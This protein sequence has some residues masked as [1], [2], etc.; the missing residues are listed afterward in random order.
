MAIAT[1]SIDIV[2]KLASLQEGLDRAGRLNEKAA[3]QIEQRWAALESGA[4]R[5]GAAIG[6]AFA[7]QEFAR[8]ALATVSAIDALNDAKDATGSTIERL[9]ALDEIA[10]KNGATMDTVTGALVKF[11]SV[12]KAADGKNGVSQALQAIGVDAAQLRQQDPADALR[13]VAVALT[14]FADNGEKARI[15]QEL[16]GKSIREVAPFLND[17]AAA[18]ELNGKVTQQQADEAE[19]FNKNLAALQATAGGFAR[20]LASEVVPYL[21]KSINL[22]KELSSGPGFFTATA[23]VFKGN[24]FTDN[25]QAYQF[26]ASKLGAIDEKLLQTQT[27]LQT[28]GEKQGSQYLQKKIERL[29]TERQELEKFTNAY[30][31]AVEYENRF[32]GQDNAAELA[33]RGRGATG[34]PSL[35]DIA[36]LGGDGPAKTGA[37][38]GRAQPAPFV[39]MGPFDDPNYRRQEAQQQA[40]DELIA[41]SLAKDEMRQQ[42]HRDK[43]AEAA[44]QWQDEYLLR[45]EEFS[46]SQIQDADQR[47]LALIEIE[48][49]TAMARLEILRQQ[50]ADVKAAE[51]ALDEYYK[52]RAKAVEKTDE[53]SAS[54]KDG[55]GQSLRMAIK[56]DFDGILG[57]WENLLAEMATK[58]LEKQIMKALFGDGGSGGDSADWLKLIGNFFGGGGGGGGGTVP[59]F[60]S[61]G[62][63]SGGWRMVG[64]RGP[65][66]EATGAARIFNAADTARILGGGGGRGAGV[67][68]NINV[69][70]GVG[71]AEVYQAVQAALS[72]A[73]AYTDGRLA[74]AGI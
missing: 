33:R 39:Q 52:R 47:A 22:M 36:G 40:L 13:E 46:A 42:E 14:G 17:L 51:E 28:E 8:F 48:R 71:K 4:K 41:K 60:A 23:E 70:Q 15:V 65:E 27:R 73:K 56:G 1:L 66:L 2:A 57:M 18:G 49:K 11:N 21:N 54:F 53:L 62:M 3:A 67:V 69:Q 64:E 6:G 43:L 55:L 63:H 9:S 32:T 38:A 50:G 29:T 19:R 12:L 44:A 58:A 34:L 7:V 68:N 30:K 20:T 16:F 5:L 31:R 35:P 45:T 26:Y 37:A 24:V 74:R 61:G 10:R 72:Q 25:A 59:G